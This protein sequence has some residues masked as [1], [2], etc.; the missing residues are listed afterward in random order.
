MKP[1]FD[2]LNE[3]EFIEI[4]VK[5]QVNQEIYEIILCSFEWFYY[6]IERLQFPWNTLN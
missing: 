6:K 2:R 4:A 1:S 5:F 3:T